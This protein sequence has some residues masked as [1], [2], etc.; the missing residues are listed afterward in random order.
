MLKVGSYLAVGLALL[1]GLALSVR[2][3]AAAGVS[4][5]TVQVGGV[6][7][8]L[9]TSPHPHGAIILLAGGDGNI[10]VGADGAIARPGNQLVRTRMAYAARGFAVLVPDCCVDLAAA[11]TYMGQYGPVTVVGTSRG[12]QRAAR[13]LAAGARPARLV[14]TSGFLSDASGDSDNVMRI[15][16]SPDALPPT[17]IVHHRHDECGMTSPEGVKPFLDWAGG[18]ARVVWLDGG[19]SEGDPCQAFAHHGFNGIDMQV[20]SAVASFAAR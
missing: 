2:T 14:L 18:R 15:L 3:A 13:G 12:T 20:V 10:G 8:A 1:V 4:A 19:R 5:S 7:A 11:V 17:L 16:G 6:S 9:L